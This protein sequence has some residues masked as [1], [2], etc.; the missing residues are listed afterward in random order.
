MAFDLQAYFTR[1]GL[2]GE[3]KPDLETLQRIHLLHTCAIPFENLDVL[4]RRE[5]RLE[6]EYVFE[7][8]VVAGR[9]G[10]CYEQNALLRAA[11]ESIGFV[12]EDLAA[13]VLITQPTEMPP[14]THRLLLVTLNQQRYLADVGFGGKTLTSPLRFDMDVVQ[15]TDFGDYQLTQVD[16]DFLLSTHQQ[17]KWLALY[18]FDLQPQY[19]SD[20]EVAN[21]YVSTW[22]QSHFC[23]HLMICL[24]N[25][26]GTTFTQNDRQFNDG[27][28]RTLDDAAEF[29]QLLQDKFGLRV[30]HPRYGFSLAE[31][32]AISLP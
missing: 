29:Y 9:G 5:I 26:D 28:P 10:Y 8:L 2:Q 21:Y 22:P 16:G 18:R 12:V 20:F 7:K 19:L 27:Q 23:Q 31:F 14:R 30:N 3:A 11:L 13:R 17:D 25:A 4:L 24:K 15:T 6:I 1:I 32:A